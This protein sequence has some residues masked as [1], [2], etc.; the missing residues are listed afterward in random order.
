MNQQMTD[1]NN[2]RRLAQ[3]LSTPEQTKRLDNTL[4]NVI[5]GNYFRE[6]MVVAIASDAKLAACTMESQF[7]AVLTC[8]SLAMVPSNGH[9]AL[10]P[11]GGEIDVMIQWQGYKSLMERNEDVLDLKVE[12]VHTKDSYSYDS[13]N[14]CIKGHDYDPLDPEREFEKLED[15]R[16]GYLV[17]TFK[18]GRKKYHFVKQ[19]AIKKARNCAQTKKIWDAWFEQMC[20]KTVY[21]DAY[22]RRVLPM[23]PLA[24]T[25]LDKFT[26]HD[27]KQLDNDPMR[28]V[29]AV[30]VV[31]AAPASAISRAQQIALELHSE[32]V[33]EPPQPAPVEAPEPEDMEEPEAILVTDG[34]PSMP[35]EL[36]DYTVEMLACRTE[37]GTMNLWHKHIGNKVNELPD[38]VFGAGTILRN[39]K[40]EQIKAKKAKKADAANN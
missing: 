22:A 9:V 29:E 40:A 12:L 10:I 28:V 39:W 4:G 16:G 13:I 23:D 31:S 14:E 24:N 2:V 11:R 27:D 21:R 25:Q 1:G 6:Q 38:K 32:P 7:R 5:N 8:A 26:Q 19:S 37:N 18:D 35:D 33:P 34:M 36:A 17:I 30:S 20:I 15:V 3:L